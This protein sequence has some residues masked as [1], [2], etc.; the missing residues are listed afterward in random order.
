MVRMNNKTIKQTIV[1]KA[2]P[3]DVYEVLIDSKKHSKFTGSPA[4]ISREVGGKFSIFDGWTVGENLELVQDKKIVQ[5]WCVKDDEWP[6]GHDSIVTFALKKANEG[7]ELKFTHEK[8]PDDWVDSLTKG[9]EE[10]Y[11]K[12]MKKMLDR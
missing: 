5:T 1:F 7:T 9:W 11:W 3:H 12:P 4:K 8:V 2:S 6:K 10:Y